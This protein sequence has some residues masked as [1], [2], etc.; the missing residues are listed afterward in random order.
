M[1]LIAMSRIP[2]GVN[3]FHGTAVVSENRQEA[4]ELFHLL[5]RVRFVDVQPAT[6]IGNLP[7]R[8]V[9]SEVEDVALF[10]DDLLFVRGLRRPGSARSKEI[11]R[12][13]PPESRFPGWM[14][15]EA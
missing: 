3:L 7:Q 1:P 11:A 2:G 15:C 12:E 13:T 9:R 5:F 14:S 10:L 6:V 8:P 4:D